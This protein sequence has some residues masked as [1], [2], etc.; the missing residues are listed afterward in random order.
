M[1]DTRVKDAGKLGNFKLTES[2]TNR[3]SFSGIFQSKIDE[4][5]KGAKQ[6]LLKTQKDTQNVKNT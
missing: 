5:D 6:R 4:V 3:D 2:S 1:K